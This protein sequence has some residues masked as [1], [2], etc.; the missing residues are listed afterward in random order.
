MAIHS[1]TSASLKIALDLLR[2]S[3]AA[4]LKRA[5]WL[6]RSP[7]PL[8][9]PARLLRKDTLLKN[10]AM[11]IAILILVLPQCARAQTTALECLRADGV[12]AWGADQ[13][14]GGPFVFPSDDDP[15]RLIGFEVEIAELI[16]AHLGVK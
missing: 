14:G 2:S 9:R 10:S 1:A 11:V 6:N 16:A 7:E 8:L 12:L 5:S 13:E 3:R 4:R 15:T